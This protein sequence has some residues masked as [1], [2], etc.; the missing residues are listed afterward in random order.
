MLKGQLTCKIS[1]L[2]QVE[3]VAADRC[4][5]RTRSAVTRT[6]RTA[7]ALK[8]YRTIVGSPGP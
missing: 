1:Q 8:R 2:I 7:V 4:T 3:H 5:G 6:S